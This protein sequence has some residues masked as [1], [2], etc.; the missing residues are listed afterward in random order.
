[1]FDQIIDPTEAN[2]DREF[3]P[4]CPPDA[5]TCLEMIEAERQAAMET[6]TWTEDAINDYENYLAA[7]PF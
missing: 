2:F 3:G 5:E 7:C 4:D 1:M 6:D